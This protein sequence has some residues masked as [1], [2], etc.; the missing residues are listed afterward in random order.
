MIR[1]FNEAVAIVT[2]GASGIGRA[3][4]EELSK[5]GCDVIIA[6]I[7]EDLAQQ[8]ASSIRETGGKAWAEKM[9]VTNFRDVKDV[10]SSTFERAG[11]L[12]YMFNN[13]GI[14][15]AGETILH[16][17]QTWDFITDVNIRGVVNGVQAAYP[18]MVKQGF[19][20]IVNTASVAGLLSIGGVAAYAM[21]KHAVVGLSKSLRAEASL[22]G[23]QVSVL[24]PGL[25]RTPLLGG[26]KFGIIHGLAIEKAKDLLERSWPMDP[27]KF[28]RKAVDDVSKN[29]AVIILPRWQRFFLWAIG[30]APVSL[31][32]W[33]SKMAYAYGLKK[34]GHKRP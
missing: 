30:I 11:R 9:D 23:I 17:R 2:G 22:S 12:D 14:G 20:H 28:A 7:Q 21:T 33:L 31:E 1:T 27:V 15:V 6:D 16:T 8:V 10:V 24:C 19:G 29:K 3:L 34:A 26:G 25:V 13:A 5:R 32:I 4:S 18:I